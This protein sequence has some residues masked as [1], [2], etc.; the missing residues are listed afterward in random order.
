MAGLQAVPAYKEAD[1]V[2][3]ATTRSKCFCRENP[4]RMV[5][6]IEWSNATVSIQSYTSEFIISL[7]LRV[8]DIPPVFAFII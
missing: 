6:W 5:K 7:H 1:L 3:A 4:G 2:E 8:M